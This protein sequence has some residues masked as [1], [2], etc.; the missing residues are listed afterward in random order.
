M[1]TACNPLQLSTVVNPYTLT[2]FGLFSQLLHQL[3]FFENVFFLSL[4]QVV[5][6]YSIIHF[7]GNFETAICAIVN[8]SKCSCANC[9]TYFDIVLL[10][11]M[12]IFISDTKTYRNKSKSYQF[13]F[14]SLSRC[15][16]A[17]FQRSAP[18]YLISLDSLLQVVV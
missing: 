9:I 12:K 6:Y 13:S 10:D 3:E 2:V 18:S 16:E 8:F 17:I 1:S 4:G 11:P 15:L 5:K 7:N 14:K